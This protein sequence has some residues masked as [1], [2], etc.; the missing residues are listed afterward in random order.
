MAEKTPAVGGSASTTDRA[1]GGR[2]STADKATPRNIVAATGTFGGANVSAQQI[3]DAMT[4][5]VLQCAR[6]GITDDA[7][8]LSRKLDARSLITGS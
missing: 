8:I 3:E 7:T 2:P 1:V 5:A 6:E 4:E